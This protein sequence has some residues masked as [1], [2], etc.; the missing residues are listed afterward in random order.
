MDIS[1]YKLDKCEGESKL[2]SK[3][4][5]FHLRYYLEGETEIL[6]KWMYEI[7]SQYHPAG[8]GTSFRKESPCTY[9]GYRFL[10]SD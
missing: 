2:Y 6:E 5:R 9:S 10:S 8:Y 7:L 4:E 1:Q 3:Y